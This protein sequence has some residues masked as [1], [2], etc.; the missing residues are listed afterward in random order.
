[1][2]FS[3]GFS[4]LAALNNRE[5]VYGFGKGADDRR[6]LDIA[7]QLARRGM[8]RNQQRARLAGAQHRAV[9]PAR[10]RGGVRAVERALV[11]NPNDL[12]IVGSMAAG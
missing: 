8:K 4:Y 6:T 2:A 11:L 9:H 3:D 7:L 10:Y 5:F 1:M 12:I